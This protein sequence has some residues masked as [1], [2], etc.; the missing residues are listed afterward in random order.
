MPG[1]VIIGAGPGLGR[2][3]ARR[4]AGERLPI[5]LVARGTSMR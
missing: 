5:A 2:A 4:F 3:V 1:A